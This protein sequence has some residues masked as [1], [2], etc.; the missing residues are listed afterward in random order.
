MPDMDRGQLA[1]C[2]HWEQT[3][4]RLPVLV[5]DLDR[6]EAWHCRPSGDG[7]YARLLCRAKGW[8]QLALTEEETDRLNAPMRR[9][10]AS[11]RHPLRD[12]GCS[13]ALRKFEETM[14]RAIDRLCETAVSAAQLPFVGVLA[15]G[16]L[17]RYFPAEHRVRC[18]FSFAPLA[19]DDVLR[20]MGLVRAPSELL[21][22]TVSLEV[23]MRGA[24]GSITGRSLPAAQ[25]D[26]P[27][28]LLTGEPIPGLPQMLGVPGG[29]VRFLVD[30][31]ACR[32][33]LAGLGLPETGVLMAVGLSARDG[34]L[35]CHLN[36]RALRETV[37]GPVEPVKLA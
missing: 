17:S 4:Q 10:I 8:P 35:M 6:G 22:R 9:Y 5:L 14:G 18:M 27:L 1:A 7:A 15:I 36:S 31:K 2:R 37:C 12:E 11:G 16:R 28:E 34:Q 13:A 26:T 30:G 29:E 20:F 33:K 3:G 23:L 19:P 21:G 25:A 24:D 32:M